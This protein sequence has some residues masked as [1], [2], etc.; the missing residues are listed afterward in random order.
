MQK[1]VN[2]KY[3]WYTWS[4]TWQNMYENC[5]WYEHEYIPEVLRMQKD[6]SLTT[7]TH[8]IQEK[9]EKR[10]FCEKTTDIWHLF[11]LSRCTFSILYN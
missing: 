11:V 1:Y 8:W 7:F 10:D 3:V 5:P 2:K 4:A 6:N 9:P